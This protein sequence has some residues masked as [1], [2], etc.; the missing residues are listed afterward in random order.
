MHVPAYNFTLVN[1][2]VQAT[3]ATWYGLD[4]PGFESRRERDFFRTRPDRPW[5]PHSLL[6]NWFRVSFPGIKQ[7]GRGDDHPLP[8]TPEVQ[9]RVQLYVY[10]PSGS[11]WPVLG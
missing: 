10:S 7:P 9:E 11:S 6:Q 5:S 2:I 8:S 3:S 1:G 4:G